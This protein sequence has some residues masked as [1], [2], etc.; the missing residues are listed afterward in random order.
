[1]KRALLCTAMLA[2]FALACQPASPPPA[3][4]TDTPPTTSASPTI[5]GAWQPERYLL[6]DGSE[7]A[8]TGQIFFAEADWTVLFFVLGDDGEPKRGS[9]EGGT[10]TLKDDS[11]VFTHTY[12][13]SSG[14]ATG[15]LAESPLRME[16]HDAS[17]ADTEPCTIDL[18]A[19]DL[20]IYFPSG[21]A[22]TFRRRSGMSL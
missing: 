16:I 9:G 21:N 13:L 19:D 18:K 3:A 10:Y 11:L 5:H 6:K 1:M 4:S 12:H 20:T 7:L 15:S 14:E 22:M 2:F 8:V 17:E